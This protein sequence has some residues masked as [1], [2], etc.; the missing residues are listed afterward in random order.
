MRHVEVHAL[1]PAA[2]APAAFD[3]LVDFQR[4]PA[5]VDVV[6]S[7]T[8]RSAP[9]DLP[10]VS[11]WEVYFR[12]GILS[13]T[14][15]DHLR[16][17]ALTIEFE[18]TEGDFDEFTGSWVLRQRDDGVRVVFAADFDFGVPSLASIVDPVAERVLTETIQLILRGLFAGAE[19]ARSPELIG[20][21]HGPAEH[22]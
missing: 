3:T 16:R 21:H 12:N 8:I 17:D 2:A 18:T 5:L 15:V 1:L 10:M 20:A 11:S 4:Y 13:W 7:V 19:F 9:G 22:V 14:E 6:R